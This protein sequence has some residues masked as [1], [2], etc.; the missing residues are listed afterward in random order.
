MFFN[1]FNILLIRIKEYA[2]LSSQSIYSYF[3]LLV[4]VINSLKH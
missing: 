4:I 3:Y 1:I 2:L